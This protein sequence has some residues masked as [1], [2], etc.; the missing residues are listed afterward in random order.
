MGALKTLIAHVI[1]DADQ[2]DNGVGA[3][4]LSPQC[5]AVIDVDTADAHMRK[6]A[7]FASALAIAREQ[8]DA[9]AI[10]GQSWQ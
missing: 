9:M 5:V 6:H 10:G 4:E 1:K 8:Q 3:L 2:V 7:H